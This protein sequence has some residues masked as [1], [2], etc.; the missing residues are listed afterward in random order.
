MVFL[1]LSRTLSSPLKVPFTY[2]FYRYL[3]S[4][5]YDEPSSPRVNRRVP[6]QNLLVSVNFETTSYSLVYQ[7]AESTVSI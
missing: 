3:W 7:R 4:I 2:S 6:L 5:D 1:L